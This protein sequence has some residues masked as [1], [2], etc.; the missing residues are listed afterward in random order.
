M[1]GRSAVRKKGKESEPKT[2]QTRPD[3]TL[4]ID[5]PC[6]GDRV[7]SGHYAVRISAPDC[8]TVEIAVD[9]GEWMPCRRDVGYY[10][11]DWT[12]AKGGR[13]TIRVRG[14]KNGG[15]RAKRSECRTCWVVVPSQN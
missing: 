1:L 9:E 7:L 4:T 3:A 14:S 2:V 15:R 5:Y 13:H 12:P 6:E 8:D 11:F 10:W